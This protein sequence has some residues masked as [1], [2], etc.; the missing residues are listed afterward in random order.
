MRASIR[1]LNNYLYMIANKGMT[2]NGKRI[3]TE[4]SVSEVIKPRYQ[5][6]GPSYGNKYVFHMYG[7]GIYTTSYL[8]DIVIDHEV[9]RGHLGNSDGLISGYF[10]WGSYCFSYVING[11]LNGYGN[12]TTTIYEVE[13]VLVHSAVNDYFAQI[14]NE[15]M[16]LE[17]Q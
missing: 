5:Y 8:N 7:L 1:H 12:K 15:Q 16:N 14:K 13:R 11:A 6:H 3:L 2:K 9:A 17:A 10:Y 4:T